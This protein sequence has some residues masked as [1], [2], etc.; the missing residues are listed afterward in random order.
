M[1]Q[2]HDGSTSTF[3][4]Y[5]VEG[6]EAFHHNKSQVTNIRTPTLSNNTTSTKRVSNNKQ[7][8][9]P[10]NQSLSPSSDPPL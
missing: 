3:N 10:N 5:D 6:D 7:N 4:E 2:N 9:S 8:S 1:F